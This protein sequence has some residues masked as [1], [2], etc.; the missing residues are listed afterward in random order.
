MPL[1]VGQILGYAY[2]DKS[3]ML[4]EAKSFGIS[5]EDIADFSEDDYKVKSLVDKILL[6][7]K[8]VAVS[9]SLKDSAVITKT[10]DEEKMPLFYT[11]C[12]Q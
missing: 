4:S 9:S 7:K 8:P 12:N 10:L 11:G 5:E 2:F 6:R 3:L 1:E